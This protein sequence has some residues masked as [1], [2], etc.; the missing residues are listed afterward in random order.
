MYPNLNWSEKKIELPLSSRIYPPFAEDDPKRRKPDITLAK[1]NLNWNPK[2]D[3]E[4][5]L[6]NTIKYFKNINEIN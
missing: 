3:L 5:G 6:L 4:Y 1:D 2:C